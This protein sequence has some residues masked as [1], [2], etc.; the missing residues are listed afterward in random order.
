MKILHLSDLHFGKRLNN[1]S[2]LEDQIYV[3]Q[4]IFQL[5]KNQKIDAV[6]IAGDIFDKSIPS[7]D[8]VQLFDEFLNFWAEL[9]LPIFIISGNHDSAERLSFGL[10]IFSHNNIYI[11]PVYNGEIKS[12]T[13]KD[14]Y[15]NINFYLLPFLK[16]SMVRPFFPDEEIK[17]HTQALKIALKNLPLNKDERNILIAHQFVTGAVVSDSE[18]INVGGLDNID[19]HIFDDFDYVALGHIHTP[20]TILR[21]TIRYCGSLLKYSF[22]EANQQKSATII[23]ITTKEQISITTFPIKPLHD[24]RKIKG[25]YAELTNRQ[26]YINTNTDDYIFATLTDEED[27]PD[28]ISRL[29]SIYPNIM[30]LEY[31]NKR[32]RTNQIIDTSDINSLKTPIE[33]FNE[34]YQLQNNQSLND[35]QMQI[36]QDLIDSIWEEQP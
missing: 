3:N 36:M 31:D 20:Q 23:D 14:N 15:G 11:S 10:N 13:L 7:A 17:S 24:M 21:D 4:Q 29:R 16:P 2:L 26:N 19:A 35:A 27:I 8:A 30:Q 25:S 28:A 32:T 34:F 9:N 12:I 33:F 18:E 1:F 5:A 22:S 6:I